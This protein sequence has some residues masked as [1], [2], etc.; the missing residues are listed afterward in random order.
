MTQERFVVVDEEAAIERG[1]LKDGQPSYGYRTILFD[2][3]TDPPTEVGSDGGEPEDQTLG[4]DWRWVPELCNRLDAESSKIT[5]E[6]VA[7]LCWIKGFLDSASE[8]AIRLQ[9]VIDVV[10]LNRQ[11]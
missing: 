5:V 7:V 8:V 1:W 6:M 4:R 10:T 3:S 9:E 2:T 11:E